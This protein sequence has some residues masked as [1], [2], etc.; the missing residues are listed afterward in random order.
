MKR[1]IVAILLIIVGAAFMLA[2]TGVVEWGV[3]GR[4]WPLAVVAF[5]VVQLIERRKGDWWPFI[6]MGGGLL[7]LANTLDLASFN[8]WQV[9]WPGIIILIGV[10]ML[11]RGKRTSADEVS[12]S[13]NEDITAVL[14]G[15]TRRN[16]AEDFTGCRVTAVLGGVELD[17]SKVH[18]KKEATVDV[19]A[20]MGGI[21]LRVPEN[22]VV[23][24]RATC[25]LGG[26]EDKQVSTAANGPT[27]YLDGSVVMAGIEVKR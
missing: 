1:N 21:E 2:S 9:F 3:V 7:L 16:N 15:V 14:G 17:I 27:I 12:G 4:L 5:G 20:L 25:I 26:I 19:F 6:L 22:A 11:V 8:F 24:S 23:V 18:I 10:S 13:A